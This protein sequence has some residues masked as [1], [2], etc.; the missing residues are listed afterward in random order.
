MRLV[1]IQHDIL[2]VLIGI[3]LL[4]KLALLTFNIDYFYSDDELYR[5]A[6]AKQIIKGSALDHFDYQ[7]GTYEGGM[8]VSAILAVPLFKFFGDSFFSL[9]LQSI[10]FLS[11]TLI[12]L[13][14]F[15]EEFF[16]RRIALLAS[17]L[18][19]FSPL[20]FTEL[21]LRLLATHFESIF[22]SL[23]AVFIFFKIFYSGK[24]INKELYFAFLG[25]ICGFALFFA[26]IYFITL[27]TLLLFWFAFD[28]KFIFKKNFFIFLLSFIV[29]F[30]PWIYHNINYKFTGLLIYDQPLSKFFFI[31]EPGLFLLNLKN[32]LLFK[33]PELFEFTFRWNSITTGLSP[34]VITYYPLFILSFLGLFWMNRKS[35]LR[36]M[37][38]ILFF[39]GRFQT[40][41]AND[42]QVF[43]IVYSLVF[44]ITYCLSGFSGYD[45]KARYLLPLFVFAII[46]IA[47]FLDA[48]SAFKYGVIYYRLISV[49]LISG[50]VFGNITLIFGNSYGDVFKYKGFSYPLLV[51]SVGQ[52]LSQRG[53]NEGYI[54][55]EP[56]YR[57]YFFEGIGRNAVTL[58]NKDNEKEVTLI[59]HETE[60]EYK[61]HFYRGM[62]Y[63]IENNDLIKNIPQIYRQYY[64]EG[65]GMMRCKIFIE[66]KEKDD[67]KQRWVYYVENYIDLHN[68]MFDKTSL[69]YFYKGF[70]RKYGFYYTFSSRSQLYGIVSI[71]DKVY[72]SYFYDGL[73]EGVREFFMDD[74]YRCAKTLKHLE[75]IMNGY[76]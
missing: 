22:F 46:Q 71:I 72:R 64:F 31:N 20:N 58:W 19:I 30:S 24:K 32:L 61:R 68:K 25:L 28:K 45:F 14:L 18:F 49:I 74:P 4:M 54:G 50:S 12:V 23:M 33:L 59:K 44:V 37:Q 41:Q 1:K 56:K 5:G 60:D 11:A 27:S 40:N 2:A 39:G 9:K 3:L 62:G 36:L 34:K 73:K 7:S 17:I 53:L 35:L 51:M 6:I 38:R 65:L 75:T 43:F 26:Y 76:Y 10:M 48:L 13:F 52:T 70:G 21:S 63:G 55:F 42:K 8:F 67:F 29:G 16:N 15:L 69:D 66:S 57:K 47:L